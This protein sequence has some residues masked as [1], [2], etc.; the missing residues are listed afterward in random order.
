MDAASALLDG[1]Q[2][3]ARESTWLRWLSELRVAAAYAEH[4]AAAG[5]H[6]RA[7]GHAREL[8]AVARRVGSLDYACTSARILGGAALQ[9]GNGLETAASELEAALAVLRDKGAPLEA[10]RSARVL[11]ILKRRLGDER[12]AAACF[13]EAARAVET[14]AGG[15]RDDA[16]RAGF[17]ALPGVREVL[18]AGGSG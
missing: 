17:L 15:T 9:R 10:W 7:A 18:A 8:W 2:A 14:I 1:L 3:R 4:H 6:D 11:G 16:M 13:A 12:G 5:D